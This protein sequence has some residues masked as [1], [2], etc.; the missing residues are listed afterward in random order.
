VRTALA[1]ICAIALTALVSTDALAQCAFDTPAKAKGFTASFVRE[2]KACG[3]F[4]TFPFPN[5]VTTSGTPGC[6]PPFPLSAYGFD[7]AKGSCSI[8]WKQAVKQ[9]CPDGSPDACSTI[10]LKLKCSGLLEPGGALDSSE[11]WG[12][13]LHVRATLEEPGS[14]AKTIVDDATRIDLPQA[15]NGKASLK[16]ILP[17]ACTSGGCLFTLPFGLPTALPRCS[18]FQV[19]SV[20][21]VDPAGDTF[22]TLGSSTR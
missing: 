9:P 6:T 4:T 2:Y 20:A 18:T 15:S 16:A 8:K 17:E 19:L 14:T 7:D 3:S 12:L 1:S 13:R 11:G 21:I 5:T 10:A 22:A